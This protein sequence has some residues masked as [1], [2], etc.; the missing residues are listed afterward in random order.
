MEKAKECAL[1]R[2][3]N[4]ETALHIAAEVGSYEAAKAI[5]DGLLDHEKLPEY[6]QR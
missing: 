2:D 6:F 4:E 5:I 1:V 3:M